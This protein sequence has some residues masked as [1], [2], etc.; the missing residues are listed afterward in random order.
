MSASAADADELLR[1]ALTGDD[2]ARAALFQKHRD[3]L[4]SLVK[5]RLDRRIASRIDASDVVQ[6]AYL[7]Y[8]KRFDDFAR[9]PAQPFYLWLRRL[10]GQR[11]VDLHRTHLG[12]QKRDAGRE[13]SI[14]RGGLPEASSASL[15]AQLLG[16]RTTASQAVQRAELK[17]RVQQALDALEPIDREVLT[18]RHFELL[19]NDE[20]AEVLK[21]T[22]QAAS[23]RYVR[24]LKRIKI[25]L[26]SKNLP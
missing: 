18:L 11:L 8:R 1:R 9:D 3:R 10:T 24:A 22:K 7:D 6:E 15:A 23:N 16:R 21:I 26:D 12:A 2:A 19:S 14:Y 5:L 4:R 25:E 17:L 20:A 13:V